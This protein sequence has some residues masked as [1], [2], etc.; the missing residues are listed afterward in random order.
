MALIEKLPLEIDALS[1]LSEGLNYDFASKGIDEPLT[2]AELQ[3][4]QGMLGIRDGVL[5][6]L[7]QDQPER[8]RFRHFQ[9]PRPDRGRDRRRAEGDRR[10]AGGDVRRPR[11]RRFC[12]CRDLCAGL[13]RRFRPP[14]RS[15]AAAPRT[16]S[17]GL[18]RQD[19]ARESG[20]AAPG[21]RRMENIAAHRG[22]IK[23]KV[24]ALAEF[25][26]ERTDILGRR[27]GRPRDRGQRRPLRRMAAH[28][29][30][31]CAGR[32]EDRTAGDAAHVLL[33]R[34]ELSQASQ[35]G[36]R[37]A[38]RGAQR[39]RPARNRLPRAERADRA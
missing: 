20:A 24:H 28:A 22:G 7:G 26:C 16:V 25:H 27:R 13:L 14:C 4:M 3:G 19:L 6:D 39:S 34:P 36:R 37:Q 11:L 30:V 23:R 10:P 35:G 29:A 17:Q 2:T 8:A 38:R 1:L 18:C 15:R 12:H 32:G 5:Q 21:R 31:A 9:R 33:R